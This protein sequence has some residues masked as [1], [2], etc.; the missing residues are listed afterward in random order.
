[1]LIKYK[2]VLKIDKM[3]VYLTERKKITKSDVEDFLI[4][5]QVR[6]RGLERDTEMHMPA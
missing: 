2:N 5:F 1:V 4:L 6:S 3:K